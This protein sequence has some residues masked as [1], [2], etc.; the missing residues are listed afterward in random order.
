M[1]KLYIGN[2]LIIDPDV[3][4]EK[5]ELTQE[6]YN[7]LEEKKD[8]ILYVITNAEDPLEEV[9]NKI[10]NL[11]IGYF[12]TE[13]EIDLKRD[14]AVRMEDGSIFIIKD[15]DWNERAHTESIIDGSNKFAAIFGNNFP[16]L[17]GENHTP[18]FKALLSFGN[19]E[20]VDYKVLYNWYME[21]PSLPWVELPEGRKL[22][23]GGYGGSRNAKFVFDQSRFEPF[24]GYCQRAIIPDGFVLPAQVANSSYAYFF[25]G[26]DVQG[27]VYI[28]TNNELGWAVQ[29]LFRGAIVNSIEDIYVNFDRE[30]EQDQYMDS[31]FRD[32]TIKQYPDSTW[33]VWNNSFFKY[34]DSFHC[35]FAG[36]KFVGSKTLDCTKLELD[37]I[38]Y[39]NGMFNS[40]KGLDTLIISLPNMCAGLIG[41][42]DC[43]KNLT[44]RSLG[45][46]IG[47]SSRPTLSWMNS[48]FSVGKMTALESV[49]IDCTNAEATTWI[50]I[51][52]DT[53]YCPPLTNLRLYK[54]KVSTDL[55]NQIYLNHASVK[56]IID[57]L[58]TVE[59]KTL[60]FNTHVYEQIPA[61]LIAAAEAK[62]WTVKHRT[63]AWLDKLWNKH[64]VRQ[65][66]LTSVKSDIESLKEDLK[67]ILNGNTDAIDKWQEVEDFLAGITDTETLTGLLNDLRSEIISDYIPQSEKSVANG[68]AGLNGKGK[69][70][71]ENIPFS[72]IND[73]SYSNDINTVNPITLRV[74]SSEGYG[75]GHID[76]NGIVSKG[77]FSIY[78]GDRAVDSEALNL[79]TEKG[80]YETL[81]DY[82]VINKEDVGISLL[83]ENVMETVP[84]L[85]AD[86]K[87]DAN[88]LSINKASGT[89]FLSG[90]TTVTTNLHDTV[91]PELRTNASGQIYIGGYVRGY[92]GPT[93]SLR[94]PT[95]GNMNL[96]AEGGLAEVL[97]SYPKLENDL[98]P[99]KYLPSYVDDVLEYDTLED[100]PTEGESGKIYITTDDNQAYRWSG[101]QY[102]SLASGNGGLTI[103]EVEGTAYDGGKG[104]QLETGLTE[105]RTSLSNYAQLDASGKVNRSVIPCFGPVNNNASTLF[106]TSTDVITITT[107]VDANSSG[108]SGVKAQA[109]VYLYSGEDQHGEY[110]EPSSS[111]YNLVTERGLVRALESQQQK[112]SELE[113]QVEK[114]TAI[115]NDLYR[116][117]Q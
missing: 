47:Q 98:I 83:S 114:L 69:I 68:V 19:L 33:E 30:I 40:I 34:F 102:V 13:E 23:V 45:P 56:Y 76:N 3:K 54:L 113:T 90:S 11:N 97:E 7:T 12:G 71:V 43:I 38:R 91:R 117:V 60:T 67:V 27:K 61:E 72:T 95:K 21:D 96:V 112:I 115:I 101:T 73:T 78:K 79:V 62:G 9:N 65:E 35:T 104:K 85:D 88:L 8:N 26:T 86:N 57:N 103:G 4:L 93:H 77:D 81:S 53:N 74:V 1:S 84:T 46:C 28:E 63:A 5:I 87:L 51:N 111:N 109:T 94:Q 75:S 29:T 116:I 41:D 24:E 80:L 99:S 42:N 52:Q 2:E 82:P 50:P 17:Y 105:V 25:E 70:N 89:N 58:Q 108:Q 10:N 6:E 32:A 14:F 39:S 110:Q 22:K 20:P 16:E 107:S 37:N 31:F 15:I 64:V 55:G 59:G 48:L 66:Q 106:H 100:L 36:V 18:K 49:Y 92:T 44:V